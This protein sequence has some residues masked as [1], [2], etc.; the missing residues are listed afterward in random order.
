SSARG[1]GAHH[2]RGRVP[3]FSLR[4]RPRP[5]R[6]APRKRGSRAAPGGALTSAASVGVA[7][8][9][10]WARDGSGGC[11]QVGVG[12]GFGVGLR[13]RDES[14][15]AWASGG[16]MDRASAR[17]ASGGGMGKASA[18]GFGWVRLRRGLLLGLKG[19]RDLCAE[20]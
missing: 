4:S 14:G 18:W 15:V 2:A 12:M 1:G 9:V 8:R 17:G 5:R 10:R 16:G 19:T 7:R 11:A 13:L 6:L 3:T 20:A